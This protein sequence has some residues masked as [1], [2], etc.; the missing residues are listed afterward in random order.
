MRTYCTTKK[1]DI[2]NYFFDK[3]LVALGIHYSRYDLKKEEEEKKEEEFNT[4]NEI[5]TEKSNITSTDN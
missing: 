2:F 4:E 1:A 5:N 3:V